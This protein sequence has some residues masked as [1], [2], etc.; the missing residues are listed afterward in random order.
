MKLNELFL[1]AYI[2]KLHKILSLLALSGFAATNVS[3][4]EDFVSPL[5]VPS[6]LETLSTTSLSYQ[7]TNFDGE[8]ANEDF[9]LKET[10]LIGFGQE[11]AIVASVGNRFNLEGITSEQYNNHHNLDY[12]L[13]LIK[14]WRNESGFILQTG[15]SYYT[16]NPR[17]W[18]GRSYE[19]KEKIRK[20][21]GNT[22]W[23]KEAKANVKAAYELDDGLLPYASLGIGANLDDADRDFYYDIFAGIHKLENNFA[24]GAGMRYEFENSADRDK[25]LSAEAS[26]DY[27]VGENMAVGGVI[28]YRIAG[29]EEPKIDSQYSAEARF[30]ILF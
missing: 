23:Y 3:A 29:A 13:G 16:Y 7:R 4:A 22:R 18:Y 28:D 17:S 26:V 20:E 2:M 19:A 12:E 5:Y 14:N 1:G 6:E 30:K 8:A 21:K 10:A 9:I 11:T 15:A 25:T 27:Y 24:Y